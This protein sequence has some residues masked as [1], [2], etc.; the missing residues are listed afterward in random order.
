MDKCVCNWYKKNIND[1]GYT[2]YRYFGKYLQTGSFHISS[3]LHVFVDFGLFWIHD[4]VVRRVASYPHY[5]QSVPLSSDTPHLPPVSGL[6]SPSPDK[7]FACP[8]RVDLFDFWKCF[9]LFLTWHVR[10]WEI[11]FCMFLSTYSSVFSHATVTD[12]NYI[13]SRQTIPWCN[14]PVICRLS[15]W[16]NSVQRA[17]A[18]WNRRRSN[19]AQR[20]YYPYC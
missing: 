14:T 7:I 2:F 12:R 8:I 18:Q 6:A 16:R 3:R 13:R 19:G 1:N 9:Q 15:D 4:D 10:F 20:I 17:C 11:L 5:E